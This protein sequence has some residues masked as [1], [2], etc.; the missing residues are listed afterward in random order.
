MKLR[1][2]TLVVV[3]LCV[4]GCATLDG[5]KFGL[6][7]VSAETEMNVNYGGGKAVVEVAKEGGRLS[8]MF[9]R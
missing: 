3:A 6:S 5:I 9:Q 7:V 2:F 1:H 4:S 8:T